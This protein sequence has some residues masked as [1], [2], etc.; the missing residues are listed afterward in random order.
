MTDRPPPA[1]PLEHVPAER[2]EQLCRTVLSALG[3]PPEHAAA[4][5]R[6]LVTADLSGRASHGMQRLPTLAA[7]IRAGLLDPAARP[8]LEWSGTVALTVDGRDGFGPVAVEAALGA[9]APAAREH[10]LA[11]AAIRRSGHAGMLAPYVERLAEDGLV[12]IALTTSEALVHPAGGRRALVGTNPIGIGVP[13]RPHPFVLD[14]ST[15]AI[16][17]GEVIAHAERGQAL[18]PGRAV[19]AEGRMTTDPARALEG[20][21]SP[22]GGSKGYG[23]GLGFELLVGLLS[24][25]AFGERVTGT[26]D[27]EHPATKGDVV[28][29]VDP[30]I[31]GAAVADQL[32][33]YLR[34]LRG[35]PTAPGVERVLIPGDRMRAERALRAREG[36]PY[37]APTWARL[38]ALEADPGARES[39][40]AGDA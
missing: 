39:G 16:S 23:L 13:A 3:A 29:A 28:I 30:R 20:A 1:P 35:A 2:A 24:G 12:G 38:L 14:M 40:E 11:L 22:F 25:T 19:D 4:Q 34:E 5:A 33:A 18:P 32:D 6:L 36:I 31:A 26:L 9:I 10:G 21:I 27:T 15:A 8:R 37:P 17:A 7:R